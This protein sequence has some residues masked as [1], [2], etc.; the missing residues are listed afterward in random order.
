M[1]EQVAAGID[2]GGTNTIIGLINERGE[3][4]A[5]ESIKTWDYPRVEEFV[6]RLHA[7][8][9]AMSATA[10]AS[11]AGVG[12]GAPAG[13]PDRGTIHASNLPWQGVVP[14]AALFEARFRLPVF[15]TNDAKAAVLGEMTY[16]GAREMKNF[17]VVTLGTGLG[18]GI[19]LNGEI[20]YGHDGFAGELGHVIVTP[21]GRSCKCGRR[22]CLETYVSA[23]GIKRTAIE[24]LATEIED[25]PLRSIPLPELGSV[26]IDEAAARGD[27]I[28]LKTFRRSGEVLGLAL[29]NLAAVIHPEAI[30]LQGGAARAGAWFHD[31]VKQAMN[32]N[33]LFLYK[34]K[35]SVQ[36]S[37]LH[38]GAII[39]AS[40]L[41]WRA[42]GMSGKG[43]SVTPPAPPSNP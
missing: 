32:D 28:A 26:A 15:V 1:Q 43:G 12:V 23:T 25:S 41:V 17:A 35:I 34:G 20:I 4:L 7:I 31:A 33:L 5:K 13:N 16:G 11:I 19:V 2:I 27:S 29:A 9:V 21:G 8:A 14:I 36:R 30:F 24:L 18:C 6:E 42:T 39:G 22:G 10:G 40:A 37:T 3:C 38:G